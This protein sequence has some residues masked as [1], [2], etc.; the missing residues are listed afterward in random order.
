MPCAADLKKDHNL[1]LDYFKDDLDTERKRVI[2]SAHFY[3]GSKYINLEHR[4]SQLIHIS[5]WDI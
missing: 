5:T 4:D 2:D 1:K 3:S